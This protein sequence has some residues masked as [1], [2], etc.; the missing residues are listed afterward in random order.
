MDQDDGLTGTV[1]FVVE[2]VMEV[3]FS[4]PIS[5]CGMVTSFGTLGFRKDGSWWSVGCVLLE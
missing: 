3:E 2:R 5:M 4:F 1:V